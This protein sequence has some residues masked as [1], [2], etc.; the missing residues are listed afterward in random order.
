MCTGQCSKLLADSR[1][2]GERNL[3]NDRV[4]N[5]M[6][7]DIGRIAINEV[8]G[9][10]GQSGIGEC[11]DKL[12]T[13]RRC[14]L[15]PFENDRAAGGKTCRSF[16]HGLVQ[17]KIPGA[18]GGNGSNRLFDDDLPNMGKAGRDNPTICPSGFLSEPVD[19]I[20]R[21]QRLRPG[22]C[23]RLALLDGHDRCDLLNPVPQ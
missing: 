18:E 15:R 13:A 11:V 7:G 12:S 4:R 6:V 2:T 16:S 1:R 14:L 5:E 20:G 9:A 17:W 10:G 3:A 23:D 21:S 22:F 8:E 19:Y